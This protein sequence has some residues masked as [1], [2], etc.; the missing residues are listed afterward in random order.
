MASDFHCHR[1]KGGC[2]SLLSCEIPEGLCSFQAHPWTADR[3][4]TIPDISRFAAIGETGLD[5]YK[6]ASRESQL[7]RFRQMLELAERENKSIVIHC[8][9]AWE[10]L[11]SIRR[12]FPDQ[13]WLIHGFR[14]APELLEQLR[15]A[16]F[17]VSLGRS[18]I[19]R[20]LHP[21]FSLHRIGFE[22]DDGEGSIHE[23]FG[24]A[25]EKLQLPREDIERI[26][27]WNFEEFLCLND[28]NAPG[29]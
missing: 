18:G 1:R 29:F 10:E 16:G 24:I 14:G 27:D 26:T 11:F 19:E 12:Q 3:P 6:G 4:L 21:G 28:S 8:V 7:L 22:T 20:L 2:R 23:L 15:R 9:R 17:W 5:W 13:R 25:S